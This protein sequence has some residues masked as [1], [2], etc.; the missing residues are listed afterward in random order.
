M[1]LLSIRVRGWVVSRTEG[2]GRFW[3][4]TAVELEGLSVRF[5]TQIATYKRVLGDREL[6]TSIAGKEAEN[7]KFFLGDS[8]ET[9]VCSE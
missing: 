8:R 1:Q 5:V 4:R 9:G 7:H 2:A 3:H 6:F